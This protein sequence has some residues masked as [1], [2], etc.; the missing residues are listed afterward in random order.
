MQ[1]AVTWWCNLIGVTDTDAVSIAIGTFAGISFAMVCL[2]AFGLVMGAL[3]W[4]ARQP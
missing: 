2:M 3:S 4:I 1:Q